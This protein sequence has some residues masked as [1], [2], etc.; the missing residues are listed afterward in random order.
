MK[1]KRWTLWKRCEIKSRGRRRNSIIKTTSCR[2]Y[3]KSARISSW[4]NFRWR[5]RK[6]G[7]RKTWRPPK[8]TKGMNW[9]P[10]SETASW[11]PQWELDKEIKVHPDTDRV[12]GNLLLEGDWR[13]EQDALQQKMAEEFR[14]TQQNAA[15][16]R[17][18]SAERSGEA[19]DSELSLNH[20]LT[21][22]LNAER[23]NS[24][25]ADHSQPSPAGGFFPWKG[26]CASPCHWVLTHGEIMSF[27]W[28]FCVLLCCDNQN[29]YFE[30]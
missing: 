18:V 8:V 16:I 24:K 14:V 15:G 2:G 6:T 13:A 12:T 9:C 28:I 17:N 29:F 21:T 10:H 22:K 11:K 1:K 25:M 7:T 23:E 19:D 26:S 30:K 20:R 5:E 3:I 4:L 27:V